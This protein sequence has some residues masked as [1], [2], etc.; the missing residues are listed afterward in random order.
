MLN[1]LA[2]GAA[3][4]V[5]HF[6]RAARALNYLVHKAA[7][8]AVTNFFDDFVCVGPACVVDAM[9]ERAMRSDSWAGASSPKAS[10][11][12]KVNSHA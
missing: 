6:N 3:A 1:A 2:F 10:R 9:Y 8:S 4:N 5:L 7:G 12:Q 11:N